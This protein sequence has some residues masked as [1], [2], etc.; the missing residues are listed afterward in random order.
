MEIKVDG[1]KNKCIGCRADAKYEIVLK[2]SLLGG[3]CLCENCMRE[4]YSEIGKILIPKS[5]E[6]IIKKKAEVRN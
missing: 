4:I 6:N 3:M 1:V 2:K 5:P